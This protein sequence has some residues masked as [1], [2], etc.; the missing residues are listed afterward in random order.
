MKRNGR[1]THRRTCG[2]DNQLTAP[3][4]ARNTVHT[5][6]AGRY[7]HA[8]APLVGL[9]A[10]FQVCQRVTHHI[11]DTSCRSDPG[12]IACDPFNTRHRPIQRIGVGLGFGFKF[13]RPEDQSAPHI[14]ICQYPGV[15]QYLDTRSDGRRKVGKI[16][17]GNTRL[18]HF[19]H[20]Y[21]QVYVY[22]PVIE[23]ANNIVDRRILGVIECR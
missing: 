2:K 10:T 8:F 20:N 23:F 18:S 12:D 7:S 19:R 11:I 5:G 16:L 17:R 1:F 13:L 15:I 21:G 14:Q 9:L 3:P 22:S 6:Q 4:T